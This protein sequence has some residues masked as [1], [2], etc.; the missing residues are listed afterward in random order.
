MHSLEMDIG[1]VGA[2]CGAAPAGRAGSVK[3]GARAHTCSGHS[4]G[5][6]RTYRHALTQPKQD[7]PPNKK[8]HGHYFETRARLNRERHLCACTSFVEPLVATHG[9]RGECP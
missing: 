1:K 6:S 8:F 5:N 2:V 4:N 3:R 9:V 7:P